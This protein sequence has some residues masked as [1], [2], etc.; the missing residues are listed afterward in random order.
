[1]Q[2]DCH[3]LIVFTADSIISETFSK[4]CSFKLEVEI[5]HI[6]STLLKFPILEKGR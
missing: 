6:F 4:H 3:K 2:T 5:N 1:M